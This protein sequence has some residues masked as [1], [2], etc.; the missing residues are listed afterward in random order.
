MAVAPA[1]G[2]LRLRVNFGRALL[3]LGLAAAL[4]V[5]VQN[6]QN[7]DRSDVPGFTLPVEIISVPAGQ[8]AITEPLQIQV[9]V[10]I[11][12]AAWNQLRPGSFRATADASSARPGVNDLPVR[13]EPLEQ[14][15]RSVDPIPP[16]VTVVTE[17]VIERIVPVRL[18]IGGNVPFGY[19]Y[20]VPRVT[21]T[22]VTVAG[23]SSAI[24]TVEAAVL[25]VRLDGVTVSLN[26]T[27]VPRPVDARGAE[28][29]GVRIMPST[30]NVEVPVSQ[31]VGYKEVG[32]RPVIQGRVA[33]GYYL[34]PVELNPITV[35]VVG[36][37]T[38]LAGVNFVDTESIE[39][40]NLSSSAVRRVPVVPPE[41]LTLLQPQPVSVT[42]RVAPLT[43]AQTIRVLPTVQNLGP[44]LQLAGDLPQ[45]DVTLTGPAPTFQNLSPRDFRVILSLSNLRAGRHE[46]EPT[47]TVPPGFTLQ[48][49]DPSRIAVTLRELP[50]PVPSVT[51]TPAPDAATV[52]PTATPVP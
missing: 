13:V 24:Q 45:V 47:V 27:Y 50:T 49:V 18:D 15:V 19:A 12:S 7:P 36:S 40:S 20:L 5:V 44:N 29:R 48:G 30:V 32:I 11:P 25:E 33:A 42:L 26:G 43:I 34:E 23:P 31:Q 8:V 10:R 4:W 1:A 37:P 39:V 35:T 9:R 28:V 22:N 21:P 52:E 38:T 46:V 17:E 16:R 6:E 51:P 14:Q 3:A 41:G 2:Q